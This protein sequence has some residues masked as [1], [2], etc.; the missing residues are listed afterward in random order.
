MIWV[1]IVLS[2]EKFRSDVSEG[3]DDPWQGSYKVCKQLSVN[4]LS[5]CFNLKQ[6]CKRMK[7]FKW[8]VNDDTWGRAWQETLLKWTVKVFTCNRGCWG[9]DRRVT[10]RHPGWCF[11]KSH[12]PCTAPHQRGRPSA[13]GVF[14]VTR[15]TQGVQRVFWVNWARGE[16]GKTLSLGF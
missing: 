14:Y 9:F 8:E 13:G 10:M 1:C 7:K 5:E 4:C 11:D 6:L 12:N 2:M 16:D 3:N 15:I